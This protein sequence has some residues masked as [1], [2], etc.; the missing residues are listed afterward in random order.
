MKF[1]FDTLIDRRN[2]YATK[3]D[4]LASLFGREDL[5]PLWVADM[6]FKSPPCVTE[7]LQKIVSHGVLGYSVQPDS[8]LSSIQ[9]WLQRKHHWTVEQSWISFVPGVVKGIAFALDV[10]T[11]KG[12]NVLI[13]PPVYPPFRNVTTALGRNVINN[14]LLIEKGQFSMDLKALRNCIETTRPKLFILCNP[15][16]PGGRIWTR[17]EL[18]A[19]A[20]ICF[21]NEVLVVSD[22]IHSDLALPGYTHIPFATVSEKAASNS[23]TLMAPSKTFN[24]AGLVSSFAVISNENL[25]KSFVEYLAPRE[26]SQGTLFAYQGA[27][28]AYEQGEEWLNQAMQYIADNIAFVTHFLEE[29]IPHIKPM[30]PNASFLIWLDCRELQLSH[31]QL[32][33]LFVEKANLALNDG[34]TFGEE[35]EGFMRLNVG[36]SRKV[37]EKA[38]NNLK[39]A[40]NV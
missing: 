26:L 6:D 25:R 11:Q 21:E 31:N 24:I 18:E 37:L 10:F 35:G 34:A 12:D 36:T 22:E 23:I 19:V 4:S 39:I 13:Q 5:I 7:A 40:L 2:S 9:K 1:D 20:D 28:A 27:I 16:N 8:Y 15:H 29:N 33:D 17:E 38:L 3:T 14:P 32:V 30:Q